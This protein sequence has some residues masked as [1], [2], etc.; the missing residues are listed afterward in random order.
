M[1]KF[2]VEYFDNK[3]WQ[4]VNLE[5]KGKSEAQVIEIVDAHHASPKDRVVTNLKGKG[6]DSLKIKRLAA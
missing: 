2:K 6:E 3:K 5:I 1:Q 4:E